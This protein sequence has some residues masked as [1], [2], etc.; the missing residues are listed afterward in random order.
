M[1][2]ALSASSR[3]SRQTT[4]AGE[5]SRQFSQRRVGPATR[6]GRWAFGRLE[7]CDMRRVQFGD[8]SLRGQPFSC[9]NVSP[10]CEELTS[11]LGPPHDG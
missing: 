7:S 3:G 4:L 1:I 5:C 9:A 8:G 11:T 2:D 6:I 10:P